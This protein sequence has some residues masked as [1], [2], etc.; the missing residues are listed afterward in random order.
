MAYLNFTNLQ[1]G[2]LN[3]DEPMLSLIHSSLEE[4]QGFCV[5]AKMN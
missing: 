4:I 3:K 1:E 2:S 5:Y